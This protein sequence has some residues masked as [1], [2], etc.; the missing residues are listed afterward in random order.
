MDIPI[1]DDEVLELIETFSLTLE[2]TSGLDSRIT[3]SPVDGTVQI[4]DNE[5]M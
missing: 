5:S 2:R 1:V 4:T 3:L